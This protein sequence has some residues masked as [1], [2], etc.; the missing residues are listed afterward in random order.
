MR[1]FVAGANGGIGRQVVYRALL[2]GHHVTA[3]VRRADGLPPDPRLTVVTGA[4][5]DEP[6]TVRKAV[7]GHDAVICALGNPLWLRGR[8]GPA[9]VA[10]A[11]T[12]L[13]DA[14]REGGVERIV[15]PL[16]WGAGESVHAA[17]APVRAA[18]RVFIRRDYRDFDAAEQILETSGLNWTVAYFGALTD[19]PPGAHWSA[20]GELRTPPNLAI[21]RADV[22]QFL[23]AAAEHGAFARGRAVLSGPPHGKKE[24]RR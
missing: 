17:S 1:L 8:R 10:A 12:L 19:E 13:V 11:A 3:F 18:T 20:S 23:L 5:A 7:P 14:M 6:E 22:A 15:M 16:A 2:N 4:V 9:I 21:S 24:V